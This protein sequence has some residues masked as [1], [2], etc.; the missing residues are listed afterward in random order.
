MDG[1]CSNLGSHTRVRVNYERSQL[2]TAEAI[3]VS[4]RVMEADAVETGKGRRK[5]RLPSQGGT[6]TA[7]RSTGVLAK[8]LTANLPPLHKLQRNRCVLPMDAKAFGLPR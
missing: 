7:V 1:L 8:Y 2:R 3:G 5:L 6:E 4:V